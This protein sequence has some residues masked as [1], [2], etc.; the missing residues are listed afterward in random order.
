MNIDYSII[1]RPLVFFL[2]SSNS[3]AGSSVLMQPKLEPP[4]I[5]YEQQQQQQTLKTTPIVT[6]YD[7]HQQCSISSGAYT[8]SN[9]TQPIHE[10]YLLYTQDRLCRGNY[11]HMQC[12]RCQCCDAV[13]ADIS[14]TFY[15]KDNALLC[16]SDYIK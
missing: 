7:I 15:S 4:P 9:C 10:R 6:R 3:V 16:K 13:L 8:C 12:L 5:Q 2:G 11:W 1:I 14:S